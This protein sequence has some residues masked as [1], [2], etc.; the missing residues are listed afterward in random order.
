MPAYNWTTAETITAAKLNA[1]ETEAWRSV[2]LLATATTTGAG[3][4]ITSTTF[5][6]YGLDVTFTA[7]TTSVLAFAMGGGM[8]IAGNSQTL[9]VAIL[10]NGTDYAISHLKAQTSAPSHGTLSGCVVVSG[11]IVGTSYTAK[12]RV[13]V[14]NASYQ[15]ILNQ[16]G[17]SRITIG[18]LAIGK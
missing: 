7:T 9:T 5:S 13:A 16:D 1:L 17:S 12:L 14:S 8:Y 4:P 10:L 6:D 2:N 11:L 18:I 15:G 3:G